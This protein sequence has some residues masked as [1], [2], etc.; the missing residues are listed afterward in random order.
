MKKALQILVSIAGLSLTMLAFGQ[1]SSQTPPK[2]VKV[3]QGVMEGALIHKVEPQYPE[4]AKAKNIQ[5]NVVLHVEVGR[6]G[7]VTEVTPISGHPVLADAAVE[8][9]KQWEYKPFLLNGEP[10]EVETVITVKF[11][12]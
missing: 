7:H 4:E 8:A 11:R 9:V 3:S 1:Q 12:Q 2:R 6:D 5:G 10:V